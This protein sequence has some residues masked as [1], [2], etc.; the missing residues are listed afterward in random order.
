LS[1]FRDMVIS[2]A[3]YNM[4]RTMRAYRYIKTDCKSTKSTCCCLCLRSCRNQHT[5]RKIHAKVKLK[6][7]AAATAAAAAAAGADAANRCC[8]FSACSFYAPKR[9]WRDKGTG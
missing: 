3:F 7:L 2:T 5:H 1:L 4:F 8:S 6:N 9:A